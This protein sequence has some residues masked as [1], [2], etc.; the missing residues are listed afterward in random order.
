[1]ATRRPVV[2]GQMLN[3]LSVECGGESRRY[4]TRAHRNW[5]VIAYL[6]LNRG[7]AVPRDELIRLSPESVYST[8][9][10]RMLRN[11]LFRIKHYLE[12]LSARAGAALILVD[13]NTCRWNPD[14]KLKLDTD[15]FRTDC[16]K[17]FSKQAAGFDQ[18]DR[19]TA[20]LLMTQY[21]TGFLCMFDA[22]KMC[23]HPEAFEELYLRL[24]PLAEAEVADS[25]EPGQ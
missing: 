12:P 21:G 17:L 6:M 5:Q 13:K 19:D 23:E 1:M 18:N 14:V 3:G 9:A 10:S 11:R 25:D 20:G 16:N 8:D 24:R 15:A 7:R 2:R 4:H 22:S